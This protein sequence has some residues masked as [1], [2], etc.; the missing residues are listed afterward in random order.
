[1]KKKLLLFFTVLFVSIASAQTFNV[2]GVNYFVISTTNNTVGVTASASY[3]G[4]LV[5]PTTV[6]NASIN[7]TVVSILDSAFENSTT[8]TSI[9]IPNTVTEIRNGAFRFCTNLTSVV[10][11]NS[12]TTIGQLAFNACSSLTSVVIPNSV[13]TIGNAGF[14]SC[15]SL[16]SLTISNSLTT[17]GVGVFQNCSGLTSLNIPNSVTSLGQDAMRGCSGL[18]SVTIPSSVTSIS[19]TVFMDCTSLTSVKV[20]WATPLAITANVFQNVNIGAATLRVPV[21]TVPT[22]QSAAVW[23][24]FGTILEPEAATHL[25]FDGTN[26]YVALPTGVS[27]TL[28]GGTELTIEYWFKGT[29]V[30]SAVRFQNTGSVFIV[31]GWSGGNPQF[32][33]STD[34]GT[35]GVEIGTTA[36]VLDNTWHHVACVWK[37]NDVFATYLDGVLQNSRP[38]ANVDLPVFSGSTGSLGRLLGGA[39]YTNGNL[40]DVRIWNV[41]R[42]PEQINSSKDC[43]LQGGETG[44]IAYYKFN[45]GIDA[46][47][48]TGVTTLTDATTNANNG[49]LTNFALTGSTSNWLAGSPVTTG[50]VIPSAATVTTPVTYTQ[51][52]IASPLT[53]TA[54][55]NGSGLLWYTT[56]TG[57][58]SSTTAPTPSTATVGS[59]SYWVSSTNANG[60]ESERTEMIVTVN[61]APGTHL[62]FDG[63]NDR[64]QVSS[65]INLANTSF[66]LEFYAKRT[67]SNT[68]DYVFNQGFFSTNNNLHIGFRG[69]NV[70]LFNFYNN[71]LGISPANYV[72]DNAWHHWTCVYNIAN[73]TR[74]VYQ[75]G[76]LVGSQSGVSPYTGNGVLQIGSQNSQH[77]FDG[78]L[79]DI[80]IWNVAKTADQINAGKNCE[81]QGNESGLLAY[82]KFNQGLDAQS[83]TSQTTL[84]DATANTHNGN[85][86]NFA[87]TGTNSNWLAGSP[88]VTGSTIPSAATVSTPIVYTQG[89]TASPLT[90]TTGANGSGLLWY[91]TA[92]GGT[93]STT[94]PTPSTAT[95]GSTSYWVSSTNANGCESER[96]EMI[97]TVNAAS[98]ATHLNFDGTNDFVNLTNL[99]T[100]G[101]S[102]TKQAMIRP[103]NI[104]SGAGH[105][106]L[107]NSNEVFW[108]WSGNIRAGNSGNFQHVFADA[109][110]LLNT[111]NMLTVTYDAP[112]TTMKLYINETLVSENNSVPATI[113]GNMQIGAFGSGAVFNGDIDEVRIWNTAL[114]PTAITNTINCELQSGETDLIAYYKFNQG[115]SGVS[116]AGITTLTDASGNSNNGTLSGFALNGTTSN[117]LAGSPITTGMPCSTLNTTSFNLNDTF[118]LYPNPTN[119]SVSITMPT[120]ETSKIAVYDINGRLLI[121]TVKNEKNFNLD[122]SNYSAGIYILKMK[123]NG[124][125]LIRKIIKQ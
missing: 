30:Q 84:L 23:Q 88:V 119:G 67:L 102:Y 92:T 34:G 85:L 83:N 120:K 7:Y 28:S 100:A 41:A 51:N 79:D 22:Y 44:L 74:E 61:A 111:W 75:D 38:A 24:N 6:S 42:T 101:S 47:T 106:I 118:K 26:D 109:S 103:T 94:A 69:D 89:D 80:R 63:V 117:W 113:G 107:S 59:T 66:T 96:T 2:G 37:K 125:E 115:N 122:L 110:S 65:S 91:T 121:Q 95:V 49:T 8:L 25:N 124:N 87:L 114:T 29:S 17:I 72:S 62:N 86:I 57:G 93:S 39:E 33:V 31:A 64:I 53:A 104:S 36:E 60:C 71:D 77:F 48:N 56:A 58:T 18:T 68:N 10:I 73:G 46:G 55:A 43:E 98:P 21:G 45:Q 40:D 50:S 81:L 20:N 116:N 16:T 123:I 52:D 112:T 97:V 76:I 15:N 99:I 82:Y 32:L 14:A 108:I 90:A 105:N 12:V 9:V 70:F 3:T 27:N 5:V 19:N 4:A 78:S 13:T 54:G 1:M 11:P 35:N